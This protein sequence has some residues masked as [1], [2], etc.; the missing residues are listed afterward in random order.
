MVTL[1]PFCGTDMLAQFWPSDQVVPSPLPVHVWLDDALA[2]IGT[3]AS[4][5]AARTL[6]NATAASLR[7]IM[8]EGN[9]L[10]I[11]GARIA[12]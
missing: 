2:A 12:Y 10:V 3:R 7:G 6:L 8:V 4:M 11:S 1:S 9:A 5:L